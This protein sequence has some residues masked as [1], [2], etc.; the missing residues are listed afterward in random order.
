M[1]SFAVGCARPNG[2]V[3]ATGL[4]AH[5]GWLGRRLPPTAFAPLGTPPPPGLE[6]GKCLGEWGGGH[7]ETWGP[8]VYGGGNP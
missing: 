6:D 4:A 2:P 3:L 5:A 7:P 8:P 1:L